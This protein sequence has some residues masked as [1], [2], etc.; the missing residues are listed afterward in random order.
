MLLCLVRLCI[1]ILCNI[2]SV[3]HLNPQQYYIY[4][5][6]LIQKLTNGITMMYITYGFV[7]GLGNMASPIQLSL[8]ALEIKITPYAQKFPRYVN[9]AY[10]VVT[11]WYSE[12]LI[13]ENLLV[14]N[15]YRFVTVH[16]ML[17]LHDEP[18]I[19]K[20]IIAKILL[21]S[22]SAKISAYTVYNPFS[23]L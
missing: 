13:H 10:F 20:N 15:N 1:V 16:K 7:D 14:C 12:N 3:E 18:V 21:T 2:S 6:S 17:P 5:C 4:T 11:Y 23:F 9:F 19:R 8:P 22:C